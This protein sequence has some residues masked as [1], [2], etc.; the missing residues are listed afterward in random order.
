MAWGLCELDDLRKQ[1]AG[2]QETA[3]S[4]PS[5]RQEDLSAGPAGTGQ[6]TEDDIAR[7]TKA[8][9]QRLGAVNK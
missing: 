1:Q 7:I 8:V 3:A 5:G 2:H 6:I 9:L 4:G